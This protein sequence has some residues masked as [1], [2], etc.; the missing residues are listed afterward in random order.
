MNDLQLERLWLVHQGTDGFEMHP[1]I[2][3]LP[4]GRLDALRGL[5][6]AGTARVAR[7]LKRV[8]DRHGKALKRLGE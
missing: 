6:R 7:S 5:L 2:E 3:A 4:L 1:W 8:N